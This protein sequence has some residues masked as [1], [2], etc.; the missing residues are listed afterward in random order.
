M[1]TKAWT[2]AYIKQVSD[3][4]EFVAAKLSDVAKKMDAAGFGELY[5][6]AESAFGVYRKTL[7]SLAGAVDVTPVLPSP[8][9]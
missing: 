1:T 4:L 6:N 7:L 9:F 5:L 8:H 3:D 2:A